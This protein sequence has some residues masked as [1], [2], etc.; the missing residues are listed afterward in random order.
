MNKTLKIKLNWILFIKPLLKVVYSL[1]FFYPI[2]CSFS[3]WRI[4]LCR[5][6]NERST[7]QCLNLN[8]TRL[9]RVILWKP[10]PLTCLQI[11]L[12][13]ILL[14]PCDPTSHHTPLFSLCTSPSVLLAVYPSNQAF[15][16][17]ELLIL[18]FLLQCF[19][20]P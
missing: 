20:H 6:N 4:N 1:F 11:L 10:S 16:S 15:S 3:N 13:L 12:I 8:P 2:G 18:V 19:F 14:M 17:S 9:L 5:E 7:E